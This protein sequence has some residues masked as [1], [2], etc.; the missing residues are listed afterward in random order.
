[1]SGEWA[2]TDTGRTMARFAPSSFASSAAASIAARSPDTTIWPGEF[3]FATAKTPCFDAPS[4]RAGTEASSRP[5][6]AA[7]A[8][9]RPAPL[10]CIRRPRSRTRR[11][12]S[13][14]LSA[15]EATI[16]EY[17]PIEWPA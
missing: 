8:P 15:L 1:M 13:G 12:P 16:A 10:A 6:I 9:S 4:T 14:R 17:W 11:M 5:R 7:I 2:A 3:R